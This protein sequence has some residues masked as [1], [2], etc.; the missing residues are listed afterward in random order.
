MK[1]FFCFFLVIFL[2]KVYTIS[3]LEYLKNILVV[4]VRTEFYNQNT[5]S[6]K[7]FIENFFE[8][9]LGR[10]TVYPLFNYKLIDF[11]SKKLQQNFKNQDESPLRSLKRIYLIEYE[12]SID[13]LIASEKLKNFPYFEYVQ[14]YFIHKLVGD[15]ND[16]RIGEQYYLK[17]IQAF[18]AW[19]KLIGIVDTIVVA[20]VDT[21]VDFEHEDLKENI[22]LNNGEIG[23]DTTGK[24]KRSNGIDDDGNGYVDDYIG[25]D[26]AG[27]SGQKADND[28]RPGNG[29]GTHVAGIVGAKQNNGLGI[30]GIV[31]NV[32]ILP[33]K[34]ASDEQFNTYITKGYDGILYSA[35][36][37]AKV[38]NC[39]WGSESGSNLEND[40]VRAANSLGACVVAAAGNDGR[41][42]DFAPA[43]Y[44][45]VLSV[46]AVDSSDIKAG[47]S[48][49]SPKV[50]V[51]APG[52]KVLST[53]PGNT[54]A[55][56]DGTSMASPVAA[57]VV[58]IARLKFPNLNFEQIYELVK[59]QSDN[60][61]QINASYSGF[62][63]S[64]RV[65]ANKVVECNPDTVRSIILELFSV[66]DNDGDGLFLPNDTINFAFFL[67]N[68]LSDLYNV[69]I[70]IPV[71]IQ[72][73]KDIV[74]DKIFVGNIPKFNKLTTQSQIVI[75][76]SDNLPL[77]YL[78]KLPIE[79]YDSLGL[80]GRFNIEFQVNPS[81]RTMSFN[82]LSVTF[83]SRGNIGFNDYPQN[84]QGVGFIYK[85]SP[86]V[87]F[88]GGLLIGYDYLHVYDVVRSSNQ[89]RQSSNFVADSI[90][91]VQFDKQNN[92]YLGTCKFKTN[93][94]S[95]L[96]SDLNVV[97]KVIQPV[98]KLDSNIIF[99]NY[100]IHNNTGKVLDSLFV[101]LFFDWDIGISGQNDYCIY[102]LDYDFAYAYNRDNDT[103]PFVGVKVVNE[104]SVNFYAIDNDGR[105]EDSIGIY[106]GFSKQEKWKLISGGV[107]RNK[108]RP[109]DASMLISTGPIVLQKDSVANVSF[110]LFAGKDVFT[111]RKTVIHLN[112]LAY[113]L[114]L[115]PSK[116]RKEYDLLEISFFPNPTNDDLTMRISF[117]E[118]TPL[119]IAIFDS[120]GRQIRKLSFQNE[121][122]WTIE[123]DLGLKGLSSG[124]Y[125]VQVIT[126]YGKRNF[127]L[128]KVK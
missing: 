6:P 127:G 93:P 65:N 97:C 105:G 12:N 59:K 119:E 56:W 98:G 37:G 102:D 68:V 82:N 28:P 57:G 114:R 14:P 7:I 45:G 110:A 48:N 115:V 106:D 94:D 84:K 67:K 74:N 120:F 71:G 81:Y 10:T 16:P 99:V 126:P 58:A 26:F 11:G 38:I 95:L 25:W 15:L 121:I 55:A 88:E 62:I 5:E 118:L 40:V 8:N 116:Y 20:I 85:N 43:S 66:T 87:L 46:A 36:M 34:C 69:V 2:T 4:K 9:I 104:G 18:S 53:T 50:D 123:R 96:K 111:L 44:N 80:L 113:N 47:F 33:V 39:S 101:G 124:N 79:V 70:R 128:V 1:R 112:D 90:F 54:Y 76:L 13:P 107:R 63:G 41:Y 122:P 125:F 91:S 109:T 29:H 51:S 27:S 117:V 22:F 60:I 100:Q 73:V 75:S 61:D 86:N 23:L 21:G 72:Y 77:D 17:K 64:G 49:Y 35:V 24:D 89:S 78:M 32:K 83:N 52:V 19:E 108:S 42:S 31:P 92:Y 103:L 3:A 30:A